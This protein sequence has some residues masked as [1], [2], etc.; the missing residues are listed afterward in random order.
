MDVP[1]HKT[2]S[3]DSDTV[4]ISGTVSDIIKSKCDSKCDISTVKFSHNSEVDSKKMADSTTESQTAVKKPVLKHSAES[5]IAKTTTPPSQNELVL[6]VDSDPIV[7]KKSEGHSID[8]SKEGNEDCKP[9]RVDNFDK[10]DIRYISDG[11]DPENRRGEKHAVDETASYFISRSSGIDARVSLYSPDGYIADSESDSSSRGNHHSFPHQHHQYL[12]DRL[13]PRHEDQLKQQPR[14]H[15][16]LRTETEKRDLFEKENRFLQEQKLLCKD[17]RSP[18]NVTVCQRAPIGHSIFPMC[19]S[20]LFGT[21]ASAFHHP[22]TSLYINTV[23]SHPH[24]LPHI[25]PSALSSLGSSL[26]ASAGSSSPPHRTSTG[27]SSAPSFLSSLANPYL[28]SPHPAAMAQALAASTLSLSHPL[29]FIPRHAASLS[30]MFQSRSPPSRYHPYA[31]NPI[32]PGIPSSPDESRSRSGTPSP[33]NSPL[34]KGSPPGVVKPT[35]IA[36][37]IALNLTTS[38]NRVV[39]V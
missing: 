16:L 23:T 26:P 11:H 13:F 29:A 14:F 8:V 20:N 2:E 17:S 39:P 30:Q 5:M 37:E 31:P 1:R 24:I 4:I 19:H 18:P 7:Y 3:Q 21:N 27:T 25:P 36:R 10:S 12:R 33:T 35:P 9:Q 38:E 15:H 22:M 28:P 6:H 34:M 32:S